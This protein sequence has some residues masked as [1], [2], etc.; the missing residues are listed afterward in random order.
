MSNYVAVTLNNAKIFTTLNEATA[1]IEEFD[2]E[3][4]G[5]Y[6]IHPEYNLSRTAIV[7]QTVTPIRVYGNMF[8]IKY[9]ELKYLAKEKANGKNKFLNRAKSLPTLVR[10]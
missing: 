8:D 1:Y 9:S 7:K 4:K 6:A 3:F 10:S 5:V 2:V